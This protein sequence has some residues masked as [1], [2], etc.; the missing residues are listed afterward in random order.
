MFHDAVVAAGAAVTSAPIG[1]H[2]AVAD[3]VLKRYDAGQVPGRTAP[4]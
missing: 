3:I 1:A 2:P 4:A